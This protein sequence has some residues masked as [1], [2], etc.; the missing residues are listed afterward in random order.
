M[1]ERGL[2][3]EA[4]KLYEHRKCKALQTVGYKELFSYFNGLVSIDEATELIKRNTRRYAKR[5]MTW[6]NN[7]GDWLKIDPDDI[8]SVYN[9]LTDKIKQIEKDIPELILTAAKT[10]N[11]FNN[12]FSKPKTKKMKD[13]DDIKNDSAEMIIKNH[14]VWSMGAG[15]IPIPL[16]DFAAITY[17]QLD[18]IRQLAKI[19]EIDFKETEG[20]QLFL[21]L[22]LPGWQKPGLQEQLNSFR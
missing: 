11:K 21:R 17:I 13:I 12:S 4:R 6:F 5:Q 18:M 20:K 22:L 9:I 19:Y 1:M 16:L 14:M 10:I 15:F 3:D 2:E 7:R 8:D